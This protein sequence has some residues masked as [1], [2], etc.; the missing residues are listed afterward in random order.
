MDFHWTDTQVALYEDAVAFGKDALSAS[1]GKSMKE[2][3][4]RLASVGAPGMTIPEE[5][6]GRGLSALDAARVLEGFGYGAGTTGHL[7][8]P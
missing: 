4:S 6:G 2:I 3:W 1:T 8:G 7:F 5:Y